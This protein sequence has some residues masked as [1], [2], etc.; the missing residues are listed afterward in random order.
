MLVEEN[1]SHYRN[2][3]KSWKNNEHHK[4][5]LSLTGILASNSVSLL[6]FGIP[7]SY[8][9]AVREQVSVTHLSHLGKQK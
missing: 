7:L 9:Y 1:S 2:P 6:L 4:L 8:E 3:K 5:G